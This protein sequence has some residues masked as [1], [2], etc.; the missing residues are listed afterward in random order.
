VV[1]VSIISFVLLGIVMFVIGAFTPEKANIEEEE[2][3]EIS[4]DLLDQ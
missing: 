3:E 4:R 2:D 1:R